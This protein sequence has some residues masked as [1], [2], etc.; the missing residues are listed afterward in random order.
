LWFPLNGHPN[1]IRV[2]KERYLK[3]TVTNLND[4]N[5]TFV[6]SVN[7]LEYQGMN[8]FFGKFIAEIS[9][10]SNPNQQ[11]EIS[12]CT[13]VMALDHAVNTVNSC[14]NDEILSLYFDGSKSRKGA[15]SICLLIDPKGNKTFIS[16]RLEFD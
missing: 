15:G 11:S 14:E 10:I 9:S 12:A 7:A 3:Y 16:C 5:E 1:K 4:P 8:T 2:N 6:P 13:E